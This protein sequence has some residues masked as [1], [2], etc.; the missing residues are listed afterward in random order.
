L[1]PPTGANVSA[2]ES[3]RAQSAA[4]Y[5]QRKQELGIATNKPKPD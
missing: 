1:R 4:D 5:E 2:K 3:A